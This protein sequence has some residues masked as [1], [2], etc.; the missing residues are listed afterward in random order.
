MPG[1]TADKLNQLKLNRPV[2][3]QSYTKASVWK[4]EG[5]FEES[6]SVEGLVIQANESQH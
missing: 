2:R 4:P 3:I 5:A 6:L 1:C